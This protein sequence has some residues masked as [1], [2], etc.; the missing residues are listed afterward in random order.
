[1]TK[2]RVIKFAPRERI[3]E[4]AKKY[5]ESLELFSEEADQAIPLLLKALKYADRD[6]KNS[7][8]LVLGSF[9]KEEIVWPLYDMMSDPS[10]NEEVRQHAAIQL[11]VIGPFLKDP[12]PL[13]E[14]LLNE[15]ESSDAERRLHATFALGWEGNFQAAIPLIDRLYDGEVRIQQTAVNALCNLRDDRILGLLLDRLDHGPLEQKK[16]ILLNLW[17]F[18]SREEEVREV[19]LKHLEHEDP[20]LRFE[21]LVC[22]GPMT[23]AKKYLGVYRRCLKDKDGR[24]RELALKRLA[25]EVSESV[26]KSLRGEIEPLLKDSDINVRKTARKILKKKKNRFRRSNRL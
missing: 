12:Q 10:E 22:L 14:R 25:E 3:L 21:V 18:Y 2:N 16:T 7:I 5:V 13:T 4:K 6:L 15:I 17:R 20:E 19:Y 8:M 23:E 24:I 9:A 11:S 1:M 26:L